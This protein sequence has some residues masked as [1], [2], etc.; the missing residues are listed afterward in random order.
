MYVINVRN[1]ED[2]EG[3]TVARSRFV[4]LSEDDKMCITKQIKKPKPCITR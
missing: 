3:K 2:E 4:E 1:K